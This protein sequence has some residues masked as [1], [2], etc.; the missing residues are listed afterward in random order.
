MIGTPDEKFVGTVL[1]TLEK[2]GHDM[3]IFDGKILMVTP[4]KARTMKLAERDNWMLISDFLKDEMEHLIREKQDGFVAR[5]ND[6]PYKL[7]GEDSGAI[8]TK[9]VL[10]IADATKT[11]NSIKEAAKVMRANK[12]DEEVDNQLEQ[13]R[14]IAGRLDGVWDKF[15]KEIKDKK[16]DY[17][18]MY[19]TMMADHPMLRVMCQQ[20]YRIDLDKDEVKIVSNYIDGIKE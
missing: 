11:E 13:I 20:T 5:E 12:L 18:K 17:G 8:H 19:D 2:H 16:V 9:E 15:Y 4:S 14:R 3:S 6:P 10:V 7:S 1:S